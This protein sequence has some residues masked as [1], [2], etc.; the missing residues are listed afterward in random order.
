MAPWP[1][2]LLI[3]NVLGNETL[4]KNTLTGHIFSFFTS[5]ESLAFSVVMAFFITSMMNTVM[6]YFVNIS[7]KDFSKN[8]IFNFSKRAFANLE[9][10][11]IG[12]YKKQEIGDYIYRLSYDVWALGE[13]V[14]TGLIP[15]ITNLFFL[16]ITITIL[17]L[18]QPHLALIALGIL[19]FLAVALSVFNQQIGSETKRSETSNSALFSFIQE[20]LN[21]LK[22]VQAFNQQNKKSLIFAEKEETSLHR[23]LNVYG[24][25][26]LL[27]LLLGV[28]IAISYSIVILF[29]IKAV[30]AGTMTT[31]FLI[32]FIFYLD[33]LT[34]PLLSLLQAATALKENYIKVSRM[35]D[36]FDK[37]SQIVDLGTVDKITNTEIKIGNV[38]V[39]GEEGLPILENISLKIPKGKKTI[40]VGV[41]GSGKTTIASMLLR[42]IDP[43][44]GKIF[45]GDHEISTYSLEVLRNSI[46]YLPQD[47]VLFNDSIKNNI[48]VGSPE[49]GDREIYQAARLAIAEKFIN[50]LPGKYDFQVGE[51]GN[52]LSGGQKQRIMLARAFMKIN[53]K[54]VIF[55][56]PMSSL[57]VKSRS[58]VIK[59]I[60]EFSQGKTTIIISNV[61]DVIKQ[62][63]HIIVLSEGKIIHAG[64]NIELLEKI[65]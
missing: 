14:E 42:F 24:L 56:E 20:V 9:R 4:D 36:F 13:L 27:Y 61:V 45:I 44:K 34:Y 8:L 50:H 39:F 58:A 38:S 22:T 53:A 21:Q 48:A 46:S 17:F 63:D 59:S 10:L 64:R 2:K 3:D 25:S 18:I 30:F 35:A 54:I 37:K 51:E 11:A 47:V 55:D 43:S 29:G 65:V 12:Y 40:I 28:T 19:P 41:S 32:I 23:D 49:A 15:F 62:A 6:D 31:G 57:D 7:S 5:R 33:N 1:F 16:L 26:F 60:N 52:N